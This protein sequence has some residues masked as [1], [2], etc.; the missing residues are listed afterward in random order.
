M[1]P[2]PNPFDL[3]AEGDRSALDRFL[4]EYPTRA[5]TRHEESG[6]SL[7]LWALYHRRED[8]AERVAADLPSLSLFE[9]AALGRTERVEELAAESQE[10]VGRRSDDGF[11]ALHLACFFGRPEAVDALL[12]AGAPVDAAAA[13]PT[14]VTP[15]HSAVAGRSAA[16]VDRLLAAGAPVD[17]QQQGGFTPLMGAA[18]NGLED[19]LDR[20]L[21]AGAD[22]AVTDD[23][24]RTAADLAREKG[25][26]ELAAR[27]G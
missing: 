15:L 27:L 22:P 21:A 12:D 25:H 23:Q 16:V 17:A 20:L 10:V 8:L 18:A 14:L 2:T 19:L 24:G 6:T 7:L 4:T 1:A 5:A 26:E 13:N 3:I 11:T 9:A